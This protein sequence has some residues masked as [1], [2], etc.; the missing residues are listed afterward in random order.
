[1]GYDILILGSGPAGYVAAIRAGQL[2]KKT[3]IVERTKLG[4]MCLNWGC[5]PCKALLESAK[6]MELVK[7]AVTF[8]I[9]GV[10]ERELTFNWKMH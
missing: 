5:I 1:M 10:T 8:G 6:K 4:G 3:A 9:D 7:K 2:G